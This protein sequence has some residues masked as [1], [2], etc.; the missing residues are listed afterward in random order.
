M[1]P[2]G[3]GLG[4]GVC[5]LL[6]HGVRPSTPAQAPLGLVPRAALCVDTFQQRHLPGGP[7]QMVVEAALCSLPPMIHPLG[8][9][10]QLQWPHALADS[11]HVSSL[12]TDSGPISL[13]PTACALFLQTLIVSHHASAQKYPWLFIT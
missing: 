2:S 8:H 9:L 1:V 4:P 13:Q 12:T 5:F 3:L 7:P 11:I 6:D 10:G